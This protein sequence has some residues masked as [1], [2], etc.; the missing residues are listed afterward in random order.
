MTFPTASQLRIQFQWLGEFLQVCRP[1][2][3]PDEV[4]LRVTSTYPPTSLCGTKRPF[5][6]LH[7]LQA[8]FASTTF[9]G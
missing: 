5:W 6:A 2:E 4:C 3:M 7:S 9:E 1:A 8:R